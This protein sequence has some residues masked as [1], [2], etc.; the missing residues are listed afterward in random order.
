MKP[1]IYWIDGPWAG[2]LAIMARPRGGDWLE[3]EIRQWKTAGIDIVVSTLTS[4]EIADLELDQEPTLCRGNG[5]EYTRFPIPD[6]AVPS[7]VRSTGELLHSLERELLQGKNVAFHCRQGVGR[8]PLLAAGLLVLAGMDPDKAFMRV[9]E[10]RGCAVPET[11]E[12]REWVAKLL[13]DSSVL[14]RE[15]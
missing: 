3:G 10:A 8:S 12:Q 6:R 11:A 7:S 13:G 4:D 5:I 1:R 2:R 15:C 9:G 14:H